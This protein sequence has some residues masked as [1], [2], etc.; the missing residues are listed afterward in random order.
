MTA[1][2]IIVLAAC[3]RDAGVRI[4]DAISGAEKS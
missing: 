2:A 1:F 4:T 3:I